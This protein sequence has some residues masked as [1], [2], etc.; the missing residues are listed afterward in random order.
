MSAITE[1]KKIS[2]EITDLYNI[3]ALL[4]WDQETS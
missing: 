1:L 3:M 2:A 4:Q